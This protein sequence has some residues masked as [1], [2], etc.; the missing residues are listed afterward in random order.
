MSTARS[1][2]TASVLENGKVLVAGGKD[3]NSILNSVELYDPSTEMWTN[4]GNMS[5]ARF[6]HTASV[7]ENGKVLVAGGEDSNGISNSV[8]LYQS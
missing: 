8:E 3:S 2:H 6:D 7:L 5:T 4:T 1:D